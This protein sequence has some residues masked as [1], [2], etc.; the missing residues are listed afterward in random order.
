MTLHGSKGLE[1]GNVWILGVE[2]GILPHPD[3]TEENERRLLYAGI[4]RVR[5]RLELSSAMEEGEVSRFLDEAG[6]FG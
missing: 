4:T 6:F 2:D 5:S 1:F 3:S